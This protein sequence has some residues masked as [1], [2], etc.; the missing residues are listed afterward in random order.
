MGS[1]KTRPTNAGTVRPANSE[2]DSQRSSKTNPGKRKRNDWSV[3]SHGTKPITSFF[4]GPARNDVAPGPASSS[5]SAGAGAG[6]SDNADKT[7]AEA[8][9]QKAE[10]LRSKSGTASP[11][12]KGKEELGKD[13]G[14]KATRKV[15]RG[16]KLLPG[17]MRFSVAHR[18]PFV[19][20][21]RI[22]GGAPDSTANADLSWKL[23]RP[24]PAP[25][26][27]GP[28]ATED[29]LHGTTSAAEQDGGATQAGAK[30]SEQGG[31]RS[32][33]K[34]EGGGGKRV[35][36]ATTY[37]ALGGS[38]TG[39]VQTVRTSF[40]LSDHLEQSDDGEGSQFMA[41]N[42]RRGYENLS[43]RTGGMPL[44]EEEPVEAGHAP[45]LDTN[46]SEAG[47]SNWQALGA[48]ERLNAQAR[49]DEGRDGGRAGDGGAQLQGEDMGGGAPWEPRPAPPVLSEEQRRAATSAFNMPLMIIAGKHAFGTIDLN[50]G[51]L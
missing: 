16:A 32:R 25:K 7:G 3:A 31:S 27:A 41:A 39:H 23:E 10:Q 34:E 50:L 13:S 49:I 28:S 46:A 44:V 1:D 14:V 51:H 45:P 35:K 24:P 21:R 17:Q 26:E 47:P 37:Q 30:G 33:G 38:A 48:Q 29:A 36:C 22:A 2:G 9:G 20:P 6:A 12:G 4:G 43:G 19:A 8:S 18:L 11:H 40:D 5:A 15:G 42:V